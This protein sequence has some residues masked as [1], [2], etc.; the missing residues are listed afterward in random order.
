MSFTIKRKVYFFVIFSLLAILI[1]GYRAI[2]LVK[3]E[4]YEDI[5]GQYGL[6][7]TLELHESELKENLT[8]G[9]YS[10]VTKSLDEI[11]DG[12]GL[13]IE[14]NLEDYFRLAHEI[15][16]VDIKLTETY[17]KRLKSDYSAY[18]EMKA[19][20]REPIGQAPV[21]PEGGK[22]QLGTSI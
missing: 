6:I 21:A 19:F 9:D 17:Y 1:I 20:S 5:F 7:S 18:D 16:K 14:K 8:L 10:S 2:T 11:I 3:D 22:P 4:M 12:L 13:S 15:L